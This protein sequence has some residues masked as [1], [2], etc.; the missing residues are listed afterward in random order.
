M[1]KKEKNRMLVSILIGIYNFIYSRN[2][3][4]LQLAFLLYPFIYFF[5]IMW[6]FTWGCFR[7]D[8]VNEIQQVLLLP[9][10]NLQAL[11]SELVTLEGLFNELEGTELQSKKNNVLV[12]TVLGVVA[13]LFIMKGL[14]P[15][16]IFGTTA[17]KKG[18]DGLLPTPNMVETRVVPYEPSENVGSVLETRVVPC[19]PSE[20][21]G[22]VVETAIATLDTGAVALQPGK[23]IYG[24]LDDVLYIDT[25]LATITGHVFHGR[26]IS[27]FSTGYNWDHLSGASN[28]SQNFTTQKIYD[29]VINVLPQPMEQG[30]L[31]FQNQKPN[32]SSISEIANWV[33]TLQTHVNSNIGSEV[34][35]Q[36]HEWNIAVLEACSRLRVLALKIK[37]NPSWIENESVKLQLDRL[38]VSSGDLMGE[39]IQLLLDTWMKSK[40][41][42]IDVLNL[43]LR[44]DE[45]LS[46]L[47]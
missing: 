2:L 24:L 44:V 45:V 40:E 28:V 47:Y 29:K 22:S 1:S 32:L 37:E 16:F 9:T 14:K 13:I 26:P 6:M 36:S 31:M 41:S 10:N 3:R 35:I 46:P 38:Y 27:S 23:L 30:A 17:S 34:I 33:P 11:N 21:V 43:L 12:F 25:W 42:Q 19:E 15:E 4:V 18:G 5:F 8:P 7:V 39:L 20:Y